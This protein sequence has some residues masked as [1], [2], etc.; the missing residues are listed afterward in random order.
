MKKLLVFPT[1]YSILICSIFIF[2]SQAFAMHKGTIPFDSAYQV[3][4]NYGET[5][6][7][8]SK[9]FDV[10]EN[11][12]I[13]VIFMESGGNPFARAKTSSAKGLM[14]TIDSTFTMAYKALKAQGINIAKDPFDPTASILAGSW[15]LGSMYDQ[16]VLDLKADPYKREKT[17][18]WAAALEYYFAGPKHGIK[19]QNKITVYSKG[20]YRTIDK[21]KYSSNVINIAANLFYEKESNSLNTPVKT[22]QKNSYFD[23][24]NGTFDRGFD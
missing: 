2:C 16:A 20:S 3:I 9:L 24:Y 19:Q 6:T 1:S 7:R 23:S 11:I 17:D 4:S 8:A 22:Y 14:Q 12:I 21:N 5:I 10:P 18:S 13:G 15:Y